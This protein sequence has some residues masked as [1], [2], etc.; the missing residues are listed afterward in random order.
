MSCLFNSTQVP[1]EQTAHVK[2]LERVLPPRAREGQ[3]WAEQGA[4][5]PALAGCMTWGESDA[6]VVL[7]PRVCGE[8]SGVSEL[9][10]LQPSAVSF[11][12]LEGRGGDHSIRA[13]G[14]GTMGG[15]DFWPRRCLDQQAL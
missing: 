10:E 4:L 1:R 12:T 8:G 15:C 2:S 14:C 5:D 13:R 9:P 6:S 3:C 7:F 11:V